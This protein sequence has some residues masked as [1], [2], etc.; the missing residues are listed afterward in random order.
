M[1]IKDLTIN[2]FRQLITTCIRET[3]EDIV[4]DRLDDDPDT[5]T[6]NPQLRDRQ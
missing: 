2:E 5:L 6:L 1:H 4:S 3:V